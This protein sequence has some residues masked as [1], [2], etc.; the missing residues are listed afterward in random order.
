TLNQRLYPVLI[1]KAPV[2]F[3]AHSEAG[4][5]QLEEANSLPYGSLTKT[6]W[7]KNP[8]R[9]VPNQQRAFLLLYFNNPKMANQVMQYGVRFAQYLNRCCGEK[10]L[11]EE[12]RCYFCQRFGHITI[13]C[14]RKQAENATPVCGNCA[15]PHDVSACDSNKTHCVNCGSD[16]HAS[17]DRDCPEFIRWCQILNA[18]DPTNLLPYYPTEE[19]WTWV[20]LPKNEPRAVP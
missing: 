15:G 9:R 12:P 7:C 20:T 19:E 2:Q 11:K 18:R 14:K 6:R 8:G 4:R 17:R 1:K 10:S 3:D 13:A 5:R 16:N